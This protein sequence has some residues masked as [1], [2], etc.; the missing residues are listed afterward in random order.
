[1]LLSLLLVFCIY[2]GLE[3]A[4][5]L[6]TLLPNATLTF[7]LNVALGLSRYISYEMIFVRRA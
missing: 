2:R 4:V 6:A 5:L 7:R 3:L 1:M